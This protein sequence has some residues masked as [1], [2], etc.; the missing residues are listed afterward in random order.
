MKK[1]KR[2]GSVI[3]SAATT[4]WVIEQF[5]HLKLSDS[6]KLILLALAD[7]PAR[8][9]NLV[10]RYNLDPRATQKVLELLSQKGLVYYQDNRDYVYAVWVPED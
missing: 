6:E 9:E 8:F 3:G 2:F 1:N 5:K 7:S 10:A 4:N